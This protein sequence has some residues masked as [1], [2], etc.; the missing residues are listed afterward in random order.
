SLLEHGEHRGDRA[1]GDAAPVRLGRAVTDE[2][3]ELGGGLDVDVVDA[4][5]VLGD[6]AERPRA[7]HDLP[8]DG[9]VP[10]GRP[11]ER[12]AA[13]RHADEL[14]LA[15]ALRRV[16]GSL[17][18]AQL[19]P[20][21]LELLVAVTRIVDRGENED[22]LGAHRKSPPRGCTLPLSIASA[23]IRVALPWLT[24]QLIAGEGRS[25]QGADGVGAP[26]ECTP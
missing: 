6:D 24:R 16:P 22:L 23:R 14:G 8:T 2:D 11:H 15:V 25:C 17:S 4:D 21:L 12:V 20:V 26:G 18:Q 10:D 19:A 5:R 7:L 1:F 9:H 3:P 13:D